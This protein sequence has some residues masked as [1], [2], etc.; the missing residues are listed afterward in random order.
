MTNFG[1]YEVLDTLGRGGFAVVYRARDTLLGRSVALKALLPHLAANPELRRRFTAEARMVATLRHPNIVAC[2]DIGDTEDQPYFTMDLIDGPTLAQVIA[3]GHRLTLAEV[4]RLLQQLASAIDYLHAAGFVH[5]DIKPSNIMLDPGGRVVLM[6]FGIARALDGSQHTATGAFI[7]TPEAMSPEQVRGL[8][9]GP[10]ADIYA[11]GSL[12]YHLLAGRAPFVGDTAHV[13]YAHANESPP[14]LRESC[15]GLPD[16]VYDAVDAALQKEPADRPQS[17]ARFSQLLTAAGSDSGRPASPEPT[18]ERAPL[19]SSFG[20]AGRSSRPPVPVL[21]SPPVASSS[22]ALPRR[23]FARPLLLG[24]LAALIAVGGAALAGVMLRG[25]DGGAVSGEQPAAVASGPS[26]AG[27]M[28]SGASETAANGARSMPSAV[29]GATASPPASTP[30]ASNSTPQASVGASASPPRASGPLLRMGDRKA[31]NVA[32]QA[33]V[34]GCPGVQ[35][36][37]RIIALQ[38]TPTGLVVDYARSIPPVAGVECPLKLDPDAGSP[39]I[40]LEIARGAGETAIA[41]NIGGDGLAR[42]GYPAA[43]GVI[44][45]NG[46]WLFDWKDPESITALTYWDKADDGTVLYRLPLLP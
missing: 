6:D 22:P 1:W 33:S 3:N 24:G 38:A 45:L 41:H 15:R 13:L 4:T 11:L 7:G 44:D 37:L 19:E 39:G 42:F 36:I 28:R 31:L 23:R 12:V 35:A 34:P 30:A 40:Y 25:G 9:V 5:R 29:P 18:P 32:G 2:Y 26:P 10:A 17:A 43:Y 46:V 27:T 20:A 8:P 14:P 21:T 16:G